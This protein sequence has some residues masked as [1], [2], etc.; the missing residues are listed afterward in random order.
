IRE[1]IA[2]MDEELAQDYEYVE[3]ADAFGI[4]EMIAGTIQSQA[5]Y[6]EADY[7]FREW[8]EGFLNEDLTRLPE[9]METLKAIENTPGVIFGFYRL[10][11]NGFA[12]ASANLLIIDSNTGV[13]YDIDLNPCSES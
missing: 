2:L 13:I 3:A 12:A 4:D 10:N 5:V 9:M 11:K 8:G 6:A 1:Y 7:G